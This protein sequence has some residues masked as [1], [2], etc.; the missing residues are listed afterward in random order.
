MPF[1]H[2]DDFKLK[3]IKA[4][5]TQEKLFT[6]SVTTQKDL[7]RGPI[8]G[9]EL[10]LKI[11]F[12]SERFICTHDKHLF[13]KHPF[14]SLCDLSSSSFPLVF[15]SGRHTSLKRPVFGCCVSGAPI[16][17]KFLLLLIYLMSVESPNQ[18]ENLE[19]KKGRYF[20]PNTIIEWET[21]KPLQPTKQIYYEVKKASCKAV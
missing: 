10:M 18:P 1:G 13:T 4:P 7:S 3:T 8:P 20:H 14:S 2:V 9:R 6:F 17:T 16:H 19:G 12:I 5:H 21:P 15:S 11:T